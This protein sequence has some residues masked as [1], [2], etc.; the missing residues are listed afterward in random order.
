MSHQSIDTGVLMWN[1]HTNIEN[2]KMVNQYVVSAFSSSRNNINDTFTSTKRVVYAQLLLVFRKIFM[3][4]LWNIREPLTMRLNSL[5][6][7]Y[8]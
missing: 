7:A 4:P 5:D 2:F 8:N 3:V 1:G 6:A